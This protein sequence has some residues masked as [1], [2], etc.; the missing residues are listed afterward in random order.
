MGHEAPL[1]ASASNEAHAV[2][3]FPQGVEALRGILAHE[4]E[5]GDKEGPFVI[6][7]IGRVR[8]AGHR[9]HTRN[10]TTPHP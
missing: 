7:D 8:S 3:A 4:G 10:G 1:E 2:E 5:G 6:R 9:I